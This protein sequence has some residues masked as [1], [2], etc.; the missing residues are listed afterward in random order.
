MS[1]FRL[2]QPT[3]SFTA[4][5]SALALLLTAANL[6]AVGEVYES[7]TTGTTLSFTATS[8]GS[9][10]PTFQW[11]KDGVNIAGATNATLTLTNVGSTSAGVYNA[12][13]TNSYGWAL[14]NDLILS[15]TT[16]TTTST[17]TSNSAIAPAITTQPAASSTV[18]VGSYL[19]L[20]VAAS[21][22]PAPTF[23]WSKNGVSIPGATN[24]VLQFS[25]IA[26][27]DAGTYKV[28]ATNSAGTATSNNA[29]VTVNNPTIV[30]NSAIAPVITTQPISQTVSRRGTATFTVAA[31]GSPAP[32][33]Q[34]RKDGAPISGATNATYTI[35]SATRGSAGTYSATATNSAGTATSN[36]AVLTVIDGGSNSTP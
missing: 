5:I 21:G 19:A 9:P 10:A 28:A 17:T 16:T 30:S 8:D 34:W 22:S 14:S 32:K 24:A 20:T 35:S 15:I 31:S 13:A 11:L 7:A 12:V 29:S 18:N 27:T 36:G 4:R 33:Y 3:L 1:A 26:L 2:L 25:S 23:Q 6:R